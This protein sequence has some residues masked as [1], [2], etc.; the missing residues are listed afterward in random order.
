MAREPKAETLDQQM[1]NAAPAKRQN[2]AGLVLG[3]LTRPEGATNDQLVDATGWLP[4][5]SRAALTGLKKKGHSINSEKL[6]GGRQYRA[7]AG[8]N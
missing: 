5:T 4:H 7:K 3:L 6:E 1:P 8:A 2:K